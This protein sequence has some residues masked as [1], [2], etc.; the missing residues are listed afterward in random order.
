MKLSQVR[1]RVQDLAHGQELSA[2]ARME[3]GS[4]KQLQVLQ[5]L[6]RGLVMTRKS[7]LLVWLRH[8]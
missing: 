4:T 7:W 8:E 5:E 2:F 1:D 3:V 6:Q